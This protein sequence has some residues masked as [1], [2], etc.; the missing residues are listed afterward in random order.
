MK[1]MLRPI[2]LSF[3]ALIIATNSSCAS[4]TS[5][6]IQIVLISDTQGQK[7]YVCANIV[8]GNIS[9]VYSFAVVVDKLSVLSIPNL[10]QYLDLDS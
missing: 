8:S 2:L 7:L 6:K 10:N 4:A 9:L 1:L 5:N 3:L